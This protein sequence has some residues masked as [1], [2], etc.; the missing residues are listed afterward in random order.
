MSSSTRG[1]GGITN[2]FDEQDRILDPTPADAVE[3]VGHHVDHELVEN[4]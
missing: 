2:G 4:I 1:S 3:Y